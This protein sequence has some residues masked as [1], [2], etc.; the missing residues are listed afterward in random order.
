MLKYIF[1][2]TLI[3]SVLAFP[4][5]GQDTITLQEAI[6]IALENNYQLKKTGNNLDLSEKDIFSAKMDFLP[7]L[8]ASNSY[9][10]SAGRR[11][12]QI[13]GQITESEVQSFNGSL[14][15]NITLFDGFRNI[16]NLR[17]AENNELSLKEQ[18]ERAKQ[19][20]IFNVASQYLQLL[21]DQ[22]L[23]QIAKENL[24]ASNK[25]LEQVQA[26]VDVGSRPVA[27]LYNQESVVANNELTVIQREN[28]LDTDRQA[29]IRTLQID[30]MNEY[31]FQ[32]PDLNENIEFAS[33]NL[34]E[35]VQT[36]LA[37]RS[38][39]K[40]QNFRIKS[41]E[42]SY[43]IAKSGHYPTLSFRAGI[44]SD[45][46]DQLQEIE[47][48]NSGLPL[49][50]DGS[51]FTD[52]NNQN[53]SLVDVG[54]GD[55]FF[56]INVYKYM[57]FS[58]NIPIFSQWNT[59]YSIESNFVQ[60]KN[61]QLDLENVRLQVIQEVRQ[62]YNDYQNYEKQLESTEKAIRASE[63]ALETQQERYNIGSSTLIE[64]TQANSDYVEAS[65]NRV[66]AVYRL[67]FQEQLLKYYMGQITTDIDLN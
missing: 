45:W 47:R 56:D 26:Q 52:P 36:A 59:Q 48:N 33:Y 9:N 64:L 18:M 23:L 22:E 13:T 44:Q 27:D 49:A 57:G 38:D 39:I 53:P 65:S 67:V 2:I 40:S 21:L 7:T 61:A 29:I 24:E 43:D 32:K 15:T 14:T 19:D 51:L 12:D 1:S 34:E 62:A 3:F 20:L 16:N 50:E 35:L 28:Q 4:A 11:F 8:N 10:L 60:Y 6:T 5:K 30:P 63:K 37:N 42:Y 55:Q 17:R 41:A 25:Q 31:R 54:F 46:N 58:L 66:Q